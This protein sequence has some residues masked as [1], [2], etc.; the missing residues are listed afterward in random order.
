MEICL[1]KI[2]KHYKIRNDYRIEVY[3]SFSFFKKNIKNVLT[4]I[5]KYIIM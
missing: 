3:T 5:K 1:K 4:F 2:I